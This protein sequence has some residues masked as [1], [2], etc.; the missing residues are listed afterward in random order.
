MVWPPTWLPILT[1][2][3]M[4]SISIRAY[5]TVNL[6][7]EGALR[8][9]K[10]VFGYDV[11]QELLSLEPRAAAEIRKTPDRVILKSFPSPLNRRL[12]DAKKA[13]NLR[14]WRYR[15]KVLPRLIATLL[16]LAVLI[17]VA[18][19]IIFSSGSPQVDAGNFD[20]T[21]GIIT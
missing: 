17:A 19:G 1:G 18:G 4:I 14:S 16:G 7:E 6:G 21:S 2:L 13:E 20:G 3:A 9:L 15:W 8:D 10:E 11:P 5:V 12:V